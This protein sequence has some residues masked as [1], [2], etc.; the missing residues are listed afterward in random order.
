MEYYVC[1]DGLAGL[2]GFP[3]AAVGRVGQLDH[4]Q[5]PLR[6]IEGLVG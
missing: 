4:W 3:A 2:T 5:Q 6:G 1:G